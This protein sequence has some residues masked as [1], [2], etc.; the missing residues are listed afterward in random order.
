M[1]SAVNCRPLNRFLLFCFTASPLAPPARHSP[2]KESFKAATEPELEIDLRLDE[3]LELIVG[4]GLAQVGLQ[5]LACIQ[6]RF[7]I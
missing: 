7:S 5:R 2:G 3:Q 6:P 1:V 4:Q